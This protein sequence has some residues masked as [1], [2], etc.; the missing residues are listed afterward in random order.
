MEGRITSSK[1]DT[2]VL[3][4]EFGDEVNTDHMSPEQLAEYEYVRLFVLFMDY[5]AVKE[6]VIKAMHNTG[7]NLDDVVRTKHLPGMLELLRQE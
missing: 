1:K 4:V 6:P 2:Q 5:H 7:L 3:H